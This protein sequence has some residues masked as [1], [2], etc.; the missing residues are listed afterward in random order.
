MECK[1]TNLTLAHLSQI[2]GYSRV[3]RPL[4]SFLISPTG[5]SQALKSLLLDYQRRDILEYHWP[6]G[7]RPRKIIVAQWDMPTKTPNRHTMIGGEGL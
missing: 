2:L 5:P 4:Y 6:K 1:N 3:T 7:K